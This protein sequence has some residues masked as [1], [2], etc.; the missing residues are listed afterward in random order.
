[1]DTF[2]TNVTIHEA[3]NRHADLA[4][5][6]Y[7]RRTIGKLRLAADCDIAR[8]YADLLQANTV[9]NVGRATVLRRMIR[10]KEAELITLDKLGD[11]L[12]RRLA[13]LRAAL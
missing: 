7:F 1:V 13:E 4:Q 8:N 2:I 5:A 10:A 11:A 6:E 3:R 12:D 9:G